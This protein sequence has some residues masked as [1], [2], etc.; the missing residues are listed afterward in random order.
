MSHRTCSTTSCRRRSRGPACG[1][2]M[3]G[4]ATCRSP[5]ST[6]PPGRSGPTT[7][8]S[9]RPALPRPV[10]PA[11]KRPRLQLEPA[12][13]P[14]PRTLYPARPDGLRRR[15]QHLWVCRAKPDDEGGSSG[16]SLT[17]GGTAFGGKSC[18]PAPAD[19][20]PYLELADLRN[21]RDWGKILYY[22][23]CWKRF[24]EPIKPVPP[25]PSSIHGSP[26]PTKY[27]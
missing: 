2:S 24:P 27:R 13:R 25:N 17:D 19:P 9:P 11:R 14:D 6:R 20:G 16:L 18:K 1:G 7:L 5:R 3:S 26:D 15:T 8:G 21:W 23:I 12:L 22:I 4:S 10:V